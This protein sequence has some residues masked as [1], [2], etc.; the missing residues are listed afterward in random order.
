MDWTE[1]LTSCGQLGAFIFI[2]IKFLEFISE[3]DVMMKQI[4][5]DCE[6]KLVAI[7]DSCLTALNAS[8]AASKDLEK[9][10]ALLQQR[11]EG[12]CK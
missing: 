1:L 7:T 10:I 5:V 11:L 12:M 4:H 3:R 2:V 9:S 8:I 6:Q